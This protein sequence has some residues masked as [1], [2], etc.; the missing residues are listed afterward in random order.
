[1]PRRENRNTPEVI[2]GRLYTNDPALTGI[3]VGS[4]AWLSWLTTA[5]TFYYELPVGTFTAHREQRQR[6]GSYWIAYRRRFGVLR[7]AHLGK[8]DRLTRDRLEQVALALAADP[9]M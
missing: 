2:S 1:M 8:P 4:P 3:L 5:T 7:R 6:G 9:V